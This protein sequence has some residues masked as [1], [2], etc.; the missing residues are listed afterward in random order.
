MILTQEADTVVLPVVPDIWNIVIQK[1]AVLV[2][3]ESFSQECTE[4]FCK[5]KP[6]Y[7]L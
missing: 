2:A 7:T 5:R 4:R 1:L 3:A 6:T